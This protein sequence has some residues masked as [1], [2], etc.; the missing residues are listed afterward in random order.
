MSMHAQHG[1]KTSLTLHSLSYVL[2]ALHMPKSY[3]SMNGRR[4]CSATLHVHMS[5]SASGHA[6]QVTIIHGALLSAMQHDRAAIQAIKIGYGQHGLSVCTMLCIVLHADLLHD[7]LHACHARAGLE[8]EG[9]D[10]MHLANRAQ[11]WSTC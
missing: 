9:E 4:V 11:M 3:L 8:L 6:H 10:G 1:L 5:A 7:G 2:K